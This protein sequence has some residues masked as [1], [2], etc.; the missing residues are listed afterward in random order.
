MKRE[1]NFYY[2]LVM[3]LYIISFTTSLI[4]GCR[5]VSVGNLTPTASFIVYPM[6]YFLAILFAERYGKR[7]TKL[8]FH[9]SVFALLVSVLFITITSTLPVL[10]GIDGLEPI[11]NM[12]YRIVFS[13]I[14]AFYISQFINLEV[15]YFIN[16]FRGFKF[17][18]SSVIAATVDSLVFVLLAHV[19]TMSMD[20]IIQR[21]TSQYVI[22][23]FMAVIYTILF[24]YLID[25]VIENKKKNIDKEIEVKVNEEK[26]EKV[27]EVEKP[28]RTVKKETTKKEVKKPAAKKATK[29]TTKNSETKETVKKPRTTKTKKE[30][31]K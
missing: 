6:T 11:F 2:F 17:L 14:A 25:A 4:L 7:E 21:F 27:I 26:L 8:L 3:I 9:Y 15:Y 30:T 19:G 1:K 29:T 12:D 23:V 31:T 20:L 18:I 24:T 13:Y 16:G 22:N 5:V 10:S 28:K